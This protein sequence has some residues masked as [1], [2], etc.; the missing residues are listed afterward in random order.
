[1]ELRY[2]EQVFSEKDAC[3]VR[4]LSFLCNVDVYVL[5][6]TSESCCIESGPA[7]CVICI[8]QSVDNTISSFVDSSA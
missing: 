5:R 6:S 2:T 4:H 1:M 7:I 3:S 8:A